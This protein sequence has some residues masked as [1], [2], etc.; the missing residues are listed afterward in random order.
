M[1]KKN[2]FQ[3]RKDEFVCLSWIPNGPELHETWDFDFKFQVFP[4]R[5][6][7]KTSSSFCFWKKFFFVNFAFEIYWPLVLTISSMTRVMPSNSDVLVNCI[8][9]SIFHWDIPEAFWIIWSMSKECP[10][11]KKKTVEIKD[12]WIPIGKVIKILKKTQMTLPK[13]QLRE[14]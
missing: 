12:V 8:P 14:Y 5:Q 4:D 2:F 3:K 9:T 13:V 7:R 6:D 1:T 10:L 11:K